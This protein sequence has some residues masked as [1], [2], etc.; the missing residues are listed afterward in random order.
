MWTEF[1]ALNTASLPS[2]PDLVQSSFHFI[3]LHLSS[4]PGEFFFPLSF[5]EL[6]RREREEGHGSNGFTFSST[7][8]CILNKPI[9][10][11]APECNSPSYFPTES[12]MG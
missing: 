10:K 3:S 2:P 5:L 12:G 7:S 6:G 8:G 1:S 4:F 9:M 11:S